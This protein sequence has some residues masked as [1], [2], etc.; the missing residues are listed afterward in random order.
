[1]MPECPDG[2]K[3]GHGCRVACYRV[4]HFGCLTSHGE[5]WTPEES[6]LHENVHELESEL[7]AMYPI[8][9]SWVERG[10]IISRLEDDVMGFR[11]RSEHLTMVLRSIVTAVD[12][13]GTTANRKPSSLV[14]VPKTVIEYARSTLKAIDEEETNGTH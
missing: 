2:G 12:H 8:R 9:D 11:H 5:N 6:E 1:M 14:H 10:K 13:L 3:C 7:A 4:L